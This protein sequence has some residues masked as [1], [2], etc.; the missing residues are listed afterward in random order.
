MTDLRLKERFE[1]TKK[2]IIY[3]LNKREACGIFHATRHLDR[4]NDTLHL[5]YFES[6]EI[7]RDTYRKYSDLMNDLI[8]YIID[9]AVDIDNDIMHLR[10]DIEYLERR[11]EDS[12]TVK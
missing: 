9:V 11:K 1:E 12:E 7:D 4:F 3:E 2:K 5:L 10:L 6:D 8:A